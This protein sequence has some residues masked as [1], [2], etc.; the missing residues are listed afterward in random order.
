MLVAGADG[1]KS[2]FPNG[3]QV[4]H[5][6]EQTVGHGVSV[7]GRTNGVAVEAG[8][9]GE[10]FFVGTSELTAAYG[11]ADA[12]KI[13]ASQSLPAGTWSISAF[14]VCQNVTRPSAGYG[15]PYVEI[16]DSSTSTSLHVTTGGYW[17]VS[18]DV[19][20]DSAW[21]FLHAEQVLK[22]S[23]ANRTIQFR[24]VASTASQTPTGYTVTAYSSGYLKFTRIA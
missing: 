3:L 24:L 17:R 14:A 20:Q 16:Y 21:N 22:F 11:T 19:A 12:T 23:G 5:L 13:L 7:P 8:Y 6:S 9:V 15:M 2:Q 4:D 18:P 10:T 1:E